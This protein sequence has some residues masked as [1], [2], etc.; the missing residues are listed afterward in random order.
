[1][2]TNGGR[3]M[4]SRLTFEKAKITK[5]AGNQKIFTFPS[6]I[7]VNSFPETPAT[8]NR[9]SADNA[10]LVKYGFPPRPEKNP[11]LMKK[12]E[13][14]MQRNIKYI[15]PHVKVLKNMRLGQDRVSHASWS[16][17]G[18]FAPSGTEFRCVTAKFNVPNVASVS[19]G[20][21]YC[22]PW[23][24]IGGKAQISSS[25]YETNLCQ[26]GVMCEVRG[27]DVEVYPWMD[28]FPNDLIVID[29]F[30][31]A[32]GDTIQCLI[33]IIAVNTARAYFTSLITGHSTSAEFYAPSNITSVGQDAEWI[34]E[35]PGVNNQ[36]STLAS[37]GIVYFSDAYAT[38][39]GTGIFSLQQGK[40][41][42]MIDENGKLHSSGAIVD[43]FT[44]KCQFY[45]N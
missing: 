29:N 15:P 12:W 7:K 8:F 4:K 5:L 38:D 41:I 6:G 36:P 45:H 3:F 42:D 14:A 43:P 2:R 34:V 39:G 31:V 32:P 10:T 23:V 30:P 9:L 44:V 27:G 35:R 28:W 33:S 17:A 16:G 18:I 40:A 26:I 24:G 37:Y 1:M 21:N 20:D 11:E 22:T 25:T 19:S 13:E